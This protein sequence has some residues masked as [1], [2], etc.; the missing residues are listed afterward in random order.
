M[1][2]RYRENLSGIDGVSLRP[3]PEGVVSNYAYFPVTF[4]PGA[5]GST[6][7]DVAAALNQYD[8][9]PRKY[10]FPLSSEAACYR[11]Q[12]DPLDTLVALA[13]SRSVLTLPLYADLALSDVDDICQIV[14]SCK[15]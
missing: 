9:Y 4:D 6:R 3:V 14:R 1:V 15:K 8:I 7:D 12:F 10:F 11:G 13:A 5:F 2:A